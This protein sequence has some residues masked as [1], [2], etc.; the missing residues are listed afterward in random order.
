M[1]YDMNNANLN[2]VLQKD[3]MTDQSEQNN[4]M[5]FFDV[6]S[7]I[8]GLCAE[9]YHYYS[10]LFIDDEDCSRLWKKTALE[11]ENHQKQFDLAN[12]LRNDCEFELLGDTQ[13]AYRIHNKL[14]ELISYVRK[15][16]PDIYLAVSKAIEMEHALS[17]LHL[18][19][20]VKF[21][22]LQTKNLFKALQIDDQHHINSLINYQSILMLPSTEMH[23]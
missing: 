10:E 23:E 12:R 22:E 5:L 9:L 15:S 14:T 7:K 19:S 18:E 3:T 13:R 8:E 11:E 20:A 21:K 1:I 16:P 6:C 17:D 4:L 2:N